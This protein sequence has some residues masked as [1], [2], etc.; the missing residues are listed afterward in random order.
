M[1][2]WHPFSAKNVKKIQRLPGLC[3]RVLTE[4]ITSSI[5]ASRRKRQKARADGNDFLSCALCA[6]IRRSD[7]QRRSDVRTR[8]EEKM[9]KSI[10]SL[11]FLYSLREK[12]LSLAQTY[13][14]FSSLHAGSRW[15]VWTEEQEKRMRRMKD[16]DYICLHSMASATQDRKLSES[17]L[18]FLSGAELLCSSLLNKRLHTKH[19]RNKRHR[20]SNDRRE[21]GGQNAF[22]FICGSR[23]FTGVDM[24]AH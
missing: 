12:L 18:W 10:E 13:H 22:L 23:W 7:L 4:I 20:G 19:Q 24:R 21:R 11:C 16:E 6:L 15:H 8:H 17:I 2:I 9:K 5:K 3:S 1:L 14:G